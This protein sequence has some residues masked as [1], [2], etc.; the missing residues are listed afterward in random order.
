M[1]ISS[2]VDILFNNFTLTN[3]RQSTIGGTQNGFLQKFSSAGNVIWS[4]YF[5]SAATKIN[6][7]SLYGIQC[8]QNTTLFWWH[9]KWFGCQQ[10]C[11]IRCVW[12]NIQQRIEWFF[13]CR[14]DTNQNYV[15]STYLG[16]SSNFSVNMMGLNTDRTMMYTSSLYQ[17]YKFPVSSSPNVPLQSTNLGSNDKVFTKINSDLSSLLFST[18]YGGS[19]DDY[20]P[21]GERGN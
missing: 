17:Q 10:Y 8:C 16:G 14:M 20:D 11:S 19:G 9:H 21:V 4:S 3:A 6:L 12:S 15:S 1:A 18:Y 13:V 2:L 7:H 5:Q